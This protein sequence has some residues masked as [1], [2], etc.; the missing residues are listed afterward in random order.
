[1]SRYIDLASL[2]PSEIQAFNIS[3]ETHRGKIDFINEEGKN[4]TPEFID[5]FNSNN[6]V[7][8]CIEYYGLPN[9]REMEAIIL[10]KTKEREL[11]LS[12]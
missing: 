7:Q 9:M 6:P 12:A 2:Y 8:Y 3:P 11:A 5:A 4:V 1:M 10:N